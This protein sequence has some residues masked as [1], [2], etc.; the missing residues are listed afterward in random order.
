MT[1]ECDQGSLK[2]KGS[3]LKYWDIM[4]K[5]ILKFI[6]EGFLFNIFIWKHYNV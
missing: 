6:I 2:G 3:I 5:S 4:T 1:Y